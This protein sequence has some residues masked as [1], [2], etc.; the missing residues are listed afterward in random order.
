MP[1]TS[2]QQTDISAYIHGSQQLTNMVQ[3]DLKLAQDMPY[4]PIGYDRQGYIIL[5]GSDELE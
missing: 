3:A 2:R 1:P 5:I 4:N